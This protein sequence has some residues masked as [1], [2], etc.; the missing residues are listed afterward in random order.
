MR[1]RPSAS[2]PSRSGAANTAAEDPAAAGGQDPAV[3]ADEYADEPA[4]GLF[5]APSAAPL[6]N[7][8]WDAAMVWFLLRGSRRMPARAAQVTGCAVAGT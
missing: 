7:G 5:D 2:T 6:A 8:G 3:D 4:V 1:P